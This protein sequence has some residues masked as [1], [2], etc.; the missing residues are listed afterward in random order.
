VPPSPAPP[1]PKP[2]VNDF[3]RYRKLL[4]KLIDVIFDTI[5]DPSFWIIA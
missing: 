4:H 1:P 3:E 2:P 5:K